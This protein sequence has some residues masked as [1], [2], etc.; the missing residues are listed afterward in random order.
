MGR[1]SGKED[2]RYRRGSRKVLHYESQEREHFPEGVSEESTAALRS[3][4]LKI[5]QR[6]DVLPLGD[7]W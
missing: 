5:D 3:W 2:W 6:Q 1:V 4:G 7:L